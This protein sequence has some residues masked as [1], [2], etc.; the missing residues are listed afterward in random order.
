MPAAWTAD[1]VR[2]PEPGDGARLGE[3][4]PADRLVRGELGVHRLDGDSAVERGVGGEEDDAHPA[5]TELALEPV[6]R[7]QHGLER[8]EQI[9]GRSRHRPT[10]QGE[11]NR[12][13]TSPEALVGC[14][15]HRKG[16]SPRSMG[17][18][19]VEPMLTSDAYPLAPT[20]RRRPVPHAADPSRHHRRRRAHAGRAAPGGRRRQRAVRRAPSRLHSR[21]GAGGAG[22]AG[23][24]GAGLRPPLRPRPDGRAGAPGAG[25]PGDP[26]GRAGLA[27]RSGGHRDAAAPRRVRGASGR[28]RHLAGGLEPAPPGGGAAGHPRRRPDPGAHPRARSPRRRRT[29]GCSWRP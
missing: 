7:F 3:E 2:V 6:L 23:G 14:V 8:V 21:R 28:G 12:E 4:A 26:D 20:R 5:A 19:R 22:A 18:F 25:V 9:E 24:C 29:R 11:R 16:C 17:M 15:A 1:D 27:A 13:Y 10:G